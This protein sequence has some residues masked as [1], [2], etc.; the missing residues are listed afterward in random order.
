MHEIQFIKWQ[1]GAYIPFFLDS[2]F[3]LWFIA[4]I[5]YSRML[6]GAYFTVQEISVP[7]LCS[8]YDSVLLMDLNIEYI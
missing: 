1:K 6:A 2:Y 7:Q 8:L 3:D 5:R 4:I